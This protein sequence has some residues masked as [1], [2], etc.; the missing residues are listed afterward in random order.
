ML[1]KII[2]LFFALVFTF[3][4]TYSMEDKIKQESDDPFFMM[5]TH[6]FDP[7]LMIKILITEKIRT[8]LENIRCMH[9]F[10]EIK[11]SFSLI[12]EDINLILTETDPTHLL[13]QFKYRCNQLYFTK[14]SMSLNETKIFIEDFLNSIKDSILHYPIC[15]TPRRASPI[16]TYLNQ[17]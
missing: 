1:K 12:L 7:N 3:T 16:F 8:T 2:F 17:D 4:N 11:H 15:P 10:E 14:P 9:S 13:A 6:V 5:T